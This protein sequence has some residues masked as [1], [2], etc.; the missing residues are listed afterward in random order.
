M[1]KQNV[2]IL[3]VLNLNLWKKSALFFRYHARPTTG[4]TF[5]AWWGPTPT[6]QWETLTGAKGTLD[7]PSGV[8]QGIPAA[9]L[10]TRGPPFTIGSKA[11]V[12]ILFEGLFA[13]FNIL[14]F[15]LI[16]QPWPTRP[17]PTQIGA[18]KNERTSPAATRPRK[19]IT[20]TGNWPLT[21]GNGS[22]A[23]FTNPTTHRCLSRPFDLLITPAAAICTTSLTHW[24]QWNRRRH[25]HRPS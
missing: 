19:T 11:R 16:C 6:P 10:W 17:W 21:I 24:H 4:I 1:Y 7:P 15:H 8:A 14:A 18:G 20:E 23:N 25:L 3:N 22:A 12:Y 5:L 13:I 2:Y 9:T